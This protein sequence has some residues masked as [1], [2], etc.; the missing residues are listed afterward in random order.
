MIKEQL[1]DGKKPEGHPD[2]HLDL[3]PDSASTTTDSLLNLSITNGLSSSSSRSSN[4]NATNKQRAP[5]P[6]RQKNTSVMGLLSLTFSRL[7]FAKDEEEKLVALRYFVEFI[8]ENAVDFWMT[9]CILLLSSVIL[10]ATSVVMICCILMGK[11]KR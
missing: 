7:M 10:F 4:T 8:R 2:G 1:I 5:G 9:V 3:P 6:N 11:R